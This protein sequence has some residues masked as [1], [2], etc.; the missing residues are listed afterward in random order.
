MQDEQIE[1][2]IKKYQ[3]G[4]ASEEEIALLESWYLQHNEQNRQS[5]SADELLQDSADVWQRLHKPGKSTYVRPLVIGLTTAAAA[6]LIFLAYP[7]LHSDL[8]EVSNNQKEIAR[9]KSDT[10]M[11]GTNKAILTLANGNEI[12]LNDSK[13]QGLEVQGSV[14]LVKTAGDELSYIKH[15]DYQVQTGKSVSNTIT[16]PRGGQYRIVLSDGTKVFLNAGSSLLFPVSFDARERRVVLKGEAYF[17]VVHNDLLPFRIVTA[18][19]V[20]EDIGT[21]FNVKAYEDE[22][23]L[24]TTLVEGAVKVSTAR[25]QAILNPGQQAEVD[26]GDPSYSIKVAKANINESVAWKNGLFEFDKAD[27]KQVMSAASRWYDFKVIYEHTISNLKISGR[28]S[29]SIDFSSLI[30]LLE[31]EGARFDI[32][33]RVVTV[34]N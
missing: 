13:V 2:L 21:A 16:T 19:Q 25:H 9:L 32:K 12:E 20:I 14:A 24:K 34:K 31:F 22:P 4:T 29:R 10:I 26:A 23:I 7:F 28:I 1:E 8:S 18:R 3:N 27:L 5:L 11:P 6:L 17:E 33:G 15:T 30:S